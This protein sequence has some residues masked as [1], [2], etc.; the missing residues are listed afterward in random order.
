MSVFRPEG[1][2]YDDH[3]RLLRHTQT[4]ELGRGQLYVSEKGDKFTD[5]SR[6]I[7]VPTE[8]EDLVR[9]EQ[10]TDGVWNLSEIEISSNTLNLGHGLDVSA[11]RVCWSR[12]SRHRALR[13]Q[14]CSRDLR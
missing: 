4:S 3:G 2:T 1:K 8:D 9:F 11:L 14:A 13:A 10:R 6:R 7:I 12:Q 5:G